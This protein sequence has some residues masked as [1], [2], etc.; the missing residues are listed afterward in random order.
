MTLL[1]GEK[2]QS[3]GVADILSDQPSPELGTCGS[4]ISEV[5]IPKIMRHIW[6]SLPGA[7]PVVGKASDHFKGRHLCVQRSFAS[8]CLASRDVLDVERVRRLN[9]TFQYSFY[10]LKTHAPFNLPRMF[11]F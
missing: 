5:S 7:E 6:I 9:L 3:S 10:R 4:S 8:F 2:I 1:P 11:G